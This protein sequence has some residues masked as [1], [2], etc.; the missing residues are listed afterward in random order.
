M[1]ATWF[2]RQA[3]VRK[4]SSMILSI[5]L[6]VVAMGAIAGSFAT[7]AARGRNKLL[8]AAMIGAVIAV[9]MGFLRGLV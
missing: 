5:D 9:I 2:L 7:Y 4:A 3:H 1:A 6:W 8:K